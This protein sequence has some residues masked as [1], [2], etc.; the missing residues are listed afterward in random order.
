MTRHRA[1]LDEQVHGLMERQIIP[2]WILAS[3]GGVFVLGVLFVFIGLMGSAYIGWLGWPLALLGLVAFATAAGSRWWLETNAARQLKG[4]YKQVALLDTQTK[5]AQDERTELDKQLPSGGGPLTTRL[6]AAEAAVAKLEA[7]LP[8]EAR[9]QSAKQDL[10]GA[11]KQAADAKEALQKTHGRWRSALSAAGMP[12]NLSPKQLRQMVGH[13]AELDGVERGW[14]AAVDERDRRARELAVLSTRIESLLHDAGLKPESDTA[15]GR[16]R[17][18]RR[19]LAEEEGRMTRRDAVKKRLAAL[20]ARRSKHHRA[21]RRLHRARLGLLRGAAAG[22]ETEFIRRA[23]ERAAADGLLQQRETLHREFIAACTPVATEAEMVTLLSGTKRDDLEQRRRHAVERLAAARTTLRNLCEQR[24][25]LGHQLKM[26]ADDRRP[27]LKQIELNAVEQRLNDALERWRALAVTGSV[28]QS[29]KEE[30]ERNRQPEALQEASEYLRRLT[31]GRY[32]RVWTPWGEDVL[33]VDDE[34]SQSLGVERLSRGTREQ[35][36]LSLRLAIASLYARRGVAMPLVLDD[37]LVNFDAERSGRAAEVLRDFAAAGHQLLVFTCHEHIARLFKSLDV[38]VRRL[39]SRGDASESLD[40]PEPT[41]PQ[42]ELPPAEPAPPKKRRAR[43]KP[44]PEPVEVPFEPPLIE[45]PAREPIADELAPLEEPVLPAMLIEP[46]EPARTKPLPRA[47]E[48]E[49]EPVE[50]P[51][52][53][54]EP[55]ILAALSNGASFQHRADLPH[56]RA[57]PRHVRHHWNAE[58]FEGEL[59]DRVSDEATFEGN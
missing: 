39:P 55:A 41:E 7:M 56:S 27:A 16:L 43:A 6:Q 12:K 47:I 2:G 13:S 32:S 14:T 25:H 23:H 17:Q 33:L 49:P 28:L 8:L 57:I 48:L 40:L 26:S 46:P 37:V 20:R 30:Y 18:L 44:A 52:P 1:D 3:L 58:E 51:E 5:Q 36:F 21:L 22:D 50:L 42:V 31:G 54:P 59:D 24:G 45:P 4:C 38:S 19:E 10:A 53:E 35:L 11:Q 15:S 29:L 9:H 34:A